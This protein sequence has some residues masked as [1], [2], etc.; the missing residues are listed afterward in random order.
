MTDHYR[1]G[2]AGQRTR[3]HMVR[4]KNQGQLQP[5][6][7]YS[8]VGGRIGRSESVRGLQR[9]LQM[10]LQRMPRWPL[11]TRQD[12]LA[13][14]EWSSVCHLYLTLFLHGF[15]HFFAHSVRRAIFFLNYEAP[16]LRG[17]GTLLHMIKIFKRAS[18]CKGGDRGRRRQQGKQK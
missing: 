10:M 7:E 13:D 6:M 18:P 4:R 5:M 12:V 9:R 8:P 15:L 14:G 17:A 2:E 3:A 16:P 1:S 11:E